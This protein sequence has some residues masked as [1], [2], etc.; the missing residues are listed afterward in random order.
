MTAAL[1]SS[2]HSPL[3]PAK[4]G[5]HFLAAHSCTYALDPGFRRDERLSRGNERMTP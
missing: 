1:A 3:I 5:I 2:T 4:A